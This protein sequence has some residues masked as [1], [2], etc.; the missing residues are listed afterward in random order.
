MGWDGPTLPV[1][2]TETR[3]V[4]DLL[5]LNPDFHPPTTRVTNQSCN[6]ETYVLR[7]LPRA[8]R[9][10]YTPFHEY[11]VSWRGLGANAVGD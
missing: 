8:A 1:D 10:R 6:V 2:S 4:L 3:D 7:P 5:P 9:L 11:Q